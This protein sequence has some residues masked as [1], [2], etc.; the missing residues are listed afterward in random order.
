MTD[1]LTATG[2]ELDDLLTRQARIFSELRAN[3]STVLD[4]TTDDSL[5][6]IVNILLESEQAM[7]EL[8]QAAYNSWD[9]DSAS[10]HSL[11]SMSMVTG[12][13]RNPAT[14]GTVVLKCNLDGATLLPA[15]SQARAG[16]D[17]D[18]TWETLADFT[19]PAGPAANYNIDAQC[20]TAGEIE[21]PAGTITTIVTPVVG[22]NSVTNDADADTGDEQETDSE[23]RLRRE[24]EV[25]AGGSSSVD[26]IRAAFN[27]S[28]HMGW[29]VYTFSPRSRNS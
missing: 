24:I 10:G 5:G 1:Q 6:Q 11:T 28:C 27:R 17:P 9:P 19:S 2:L 29:W 18:N 26:N 20:I 16:N 13:Q 8:I 3:I 7:A 21:A 14:Q 22:W 15:G 23:L 4:L 12:T 25:T